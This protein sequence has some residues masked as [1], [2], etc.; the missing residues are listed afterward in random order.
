MKTSVVHVMQIWN[1]DVGERIEV[2]EDGDGIGMVELRFVSDDG[3]IGARFTIP[4]E[5]LEAVAGALLVEAGK[6]RDPVGS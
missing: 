5:M 4:D 6:R 2:G 1:D 3:K